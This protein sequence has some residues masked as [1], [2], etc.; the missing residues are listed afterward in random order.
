MFSL[1][2]ALLLVSCAKEEVASPCGAT[3]PVN[4]QR[5][6][7]QGGI[8]AP[9]EEGGISDD[10]NDDGDKERSRKTKAH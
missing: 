10:G 7:D 8:V 5:S 2:F 4:T 3:D 1:V 9:T 6:M